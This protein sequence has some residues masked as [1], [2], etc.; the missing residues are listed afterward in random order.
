MGSV[1]PGGKNKKILNC[2]V[3]STENNVHVC[4]N[5][6]NVSSILNSLKCFPALDIR[7]ILQSLK[8]SKNHGLSKLL[9][10]S[11]TF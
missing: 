1:A 3:L 8:T 10:C 4:S 6:Y 9:C 7:K 5:L 11:R 2:N